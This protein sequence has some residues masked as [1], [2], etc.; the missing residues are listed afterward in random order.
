M[1]ND[2]VVRAHPFLG[3]NLRGAKPAVAIQPAQ[4]RNGHLLLQRFGGQ[5]NHLASGGQPVG[6]GRIKARGR[7]ARA[8]GR[9]GQQMSAR[10]QRSPH[11]VNHNF[12]AG[13]RFIMRKSHRARR[14]RL[15]FPDFRLRPPRS[16]QTRRDA[17][18]A[19]VPSPRNRHN[20]QER[21]IPRSTPNP[22]KSAR[23]KPENCPCAPTNGSKSEVASLWRSDH[24]HRNRGR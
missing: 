9:F 20:P 10:F 18:G 21:K 12:L 14:K 15:R 22:H 7:L 16:Q 6:Q 2:P 3:T 13:P 1:T 11:C 24:R 23:R 4:D 8:G 17:P 5:K 19:G